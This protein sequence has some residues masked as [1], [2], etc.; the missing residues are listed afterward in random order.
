MPCIRR[1]GMPFLGSTEGGHDLLGIL[2]LFVEKQRSPDS[3]GVGG[4]VARHSV[5]VA[6][7]GVQVGVRVVLRDAPQAILLVP[8]TG[9]RSWS[10]RKQ[11]TRA[12]S[13]GRS[14]T[15]IRVS[16]AEPSPGDTPAGVPVDAPVSRP[17]DRRHD[18]ESVRPSVV[19]QP[20]TPRA[21]AVFHLDPE[22]ILADFSA[23]GKCAALPGGAVQHGVVANSE[24]IRI[25]SSACGQP[26]SH[27]AS[28][29]RASPTCRASA[30]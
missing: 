13:A 24:A 12:A 8:V 21:S 22:A 9:L 15:V 27:P 11:E 18:I 3:S 4:D 16:P 1:C 10:A 2:V 25:A 17:G 26:P 30:G 14:K 19:A 23:Q 28:A 29:A 7:L 5:R 20:I 6:A